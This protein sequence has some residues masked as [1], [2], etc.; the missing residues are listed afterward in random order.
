MRCFLSPM[1]RMLYAVNRMS[2][3]HPPGDVGDIHVSRIM[4]PDDANIMGNIHGGTI[5]KIIEEAGCVVCTRHCN[6]DDEEHCLAALVRVEKAEFL[7]PVFIGEVAHACAEIIFTS[8]HSLEVQVKVIAENILT[9]TKR[10][11]N[12]AVLWYVPISLQNIDK[13][14]EVPL[15]KYSSAELEEEGRKRYE[16]QK[17][18]RLETNTTPEDVVSDPPISETHTVGASQ[19]NLVQ[20]I[21]PGDC[22]LHDFANGGVIMKLMDEVAGIVA[23]RHCSSKIVTGSVQELNFR[24]KIKKGSVVTV[25]GRLTFVSTCSLE[26][27]VLVDATVLMEAKEVK[28]RAASGFFIYICLGKDNKPQP[29]PPLKIQGEEEQR[30]FEEGKARYQLNKARREAEKQ[31]LHK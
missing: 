4:R 6:D 11:V 16:A 20:L 15:I 23:A 8:E 28:Y 26:I 27:E 17:V 3:R 7:C 22:S 12:K 24:R 10:L 9:G 30:R 19:S 25:S 13:I 2:R 18:R 5:L 29:A 31:K 21:G 14:M 1:S